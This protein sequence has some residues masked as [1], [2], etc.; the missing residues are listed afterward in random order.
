MIGFSLARKETNLTGYPQNT[1]I[2]EFLKMMDPLLV[3][4]QRVER[5]PSIGNRFLFGC[6]SKNRNSRMA[7]AGKR[8]NMNQNLRFAPPIV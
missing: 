6:G 7:C 5:K 3:S 8:R 4:I 2:W 1:P